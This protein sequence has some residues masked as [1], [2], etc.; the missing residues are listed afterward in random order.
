MT[1]LVVVLAVVVVVIL[2][3][4]IVAVRNMRAEDPDEFADQPINRGRTRGHHDERDPRYDR[5]EPARAG[6]GAR[7]AVRQGSSGYRS[8]G[9]GRGLDERR[10]QQRPRGYDQRTPDRG[11]FDS[12]RGHDG[13]RSAPRSPSAS[14]A[15]SGPDKRR[16][17][18][19]DAP[20]RPDETPAPT[21]ARSRRSSDS[22]EWDSSEWDKLSDVDYWA[23]LASDKPLTTTAQ[24]AAQ[25]S[26]A[27][28][29][30]TRRPAPD[31]ESETMAIRSQVPGG[32]PRRDPVTGL[33]VRGPQS[34]PEAGMAEAARTDFAAAPVPVAG[35]QDRPRPAAT[36]GGPSR[37][38]RNPQER[39]RPQRSRPARE[40]D[41]RSLAEMGSERNGYDLAGPASLPIPVIRA[42]TPPRGSMPPA[43][44]PAPAAPQQRPRMTPDD[45]PL[46]SP[47]FPKIPSDS[48]SYRN[49]RASTPPG[50]S[51][52]PATPPGGSRAPATPP[53]GSRTPA[54]YQAPTQQFASYGSPE[55]QY[56]AAER[57]A[58][59]PAA[60]PR[61]AGPRSG[62]HS[63]PRSSG[64]H[65][66]PPG[67]G[68]HSAPPPGTAP[69]RASPR[70][71]QHSADPGGYP[72]PTSSA[73]P[74]PS[75]SG[76]PYGSYVTPDS[77]PTVASSY[78]DYPALSGHD[79]SAYLPPV[80]AGHIGQNG[81]GH[82]AYLPPPPSAGHLGQNGNGYWHE[83]PSGPAHAADPGGSGYPDDG[84]QVP[85]PRDAGVQ[86]NYRNGYG[87]HGEADYPPGGYPADPQNPAG[88]PPVDPYGRDGY[89]GYPEYG[90]AGR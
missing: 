64:A 35:T 78:D 23:E 59:P 3:V 54:S 49:G 73:P 40:V 39:R 5:R 61:G 29:N 65:S 36:S 51:R 82:G 52:G 19:S 21:R 8:A 56:P 15:S 80:G 20:R 30:G 77:Q 17:P 7:S 88:Y 55:P 69:R 81:N 24:P 67:S 63:A 62:A 75:P 76:N 11:D 68:A 70:P 66:A 72:A 9:G 87:E 33:P 13:R 48:R 60:A 45:D 85:D 1:K 84:A 46:T 18:G 74:A 31:H 22:S 37:P 27:P 41:H 14:R 53:G 79:P 42:N 86:G 2:V 44:P 43:G 10:D 38:E 16:R 83:R 71:A 50:G 12:D 57:P 47:S 32:V 34:P 28:R 4:V 6:R 90:A 25:P 58:A 26:A 89:G